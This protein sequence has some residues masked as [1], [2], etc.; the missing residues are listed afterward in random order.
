MKLKYKYI[1]NII[2]IFLEQ[3]DD[4]FI[5]IIAYYYVIMVL[6]Y[7][8]TNLGLQL[9]NISELFSNYMLI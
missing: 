7:V 8:N 2:Y 3:Y 9:L 1:D 6:F 4:V 5:E